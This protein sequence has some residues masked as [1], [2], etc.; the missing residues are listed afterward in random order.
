M[1]CPSLSDL[2]PP[3]CGKSGWPWTVETEQLPEKMEDGSQWPRISVVT[4]SYNQGEFVEETIRSVLLQGY[5]DIEYIII[6]GGSTDKSVDIIKRYSNWLTHWVSEKDE[7]Q[8]QAINKGM[9]Y[10]AG[11]IFNWINS[12][13]YLEPRAFEIIAR[14]YDS[15]SIVATA[16]REFGVG[17]E[18]HCISH[19]LTSHE[20][21]SGGPGVVFRQPGF[22]IGRDLLKRGFPLDEG[23]HY[24]FDWYMAIK[25][26]GCNPDIQYT[27][28]IIANFRLHEDSKTIAKGSEWGAEGI[29]ILHKLLE[30]PL[31]QEQ[32]SQGILRKAMD[33]A[34]WKSRMD[35]ILS[36]S[37]TPLYELVIQMLANPARRTNRFTLGA[38]KKLMIEK[39]TQLYT[40]L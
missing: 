35:E 18:V 38:V 5:P 19:G 4:P 25:V 13:D 15:N 21:I 17:I 30:D 12:D 36:C 33:D 34:V 11:D 37:E 2:P 29:A 31:F 14:R 7:G 10:V 24:A 26:L 32:K 22:W 9:K 3:P 1:R 16:V 39:L 20:M 27:T 6:D 28:S 8:S 23:L 40:K